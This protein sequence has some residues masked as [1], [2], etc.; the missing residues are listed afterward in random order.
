MKYYL[1]Y[2]KNN[3]NLYFKIINNIKLSNIIYKNIILIYFIKIKIIIIFI[4]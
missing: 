4:F 2:N 1:K 3:N